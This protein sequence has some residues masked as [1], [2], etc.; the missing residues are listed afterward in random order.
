MNRKLVFIISIVFSLSAAAQKHAPQNW[1]NLDWETDKFPGVSTNKAYIELLK[2]KTPKPVVVAVID[3]GT[4]INHEDLK[5]II[6]VNQKEIAGN[7]IDDDKNGYVDD[8]N[9]WSF[10]SGKDSDVR[11]DN[12]ELVRMYKSLQPLYAKTDSSGMDDKSK[13]AFREYIGIRNKFLEKKEENSRMFE[14]LGGMMQALNTIRQVTGSDNPS[15]KRIKAFE[16]STTMEGLAKKNLLKFN[17]YGMDIPALSRQLQA[18]MDYYGKAVKY[19]YNPDFDTRTIV[20]DNYENLSECCYG[21]NRVSG[22]KGEHGT[23]VAGII[24]AVR[25]NGVGMNGV[26]NSVRIMVL[27]AVPDGDER[28]KDVANAIRYAANNG[29]SIINMSFGKD[30]SPDKKT[31]DEAVKYAMSKDVLIVHAAGNDSKNTGIE[32]NFPNPEYADGSGFAP[33]WIE[34]GASSWRTKKYLTA[35]FSNY[36]KERVDLFAPGVDIYSTLPG[37]SYGS[38]NGTSMAGPVTAGVAAIIRSYYPQFTAAEV[39]EILLQSVTTVKKKVLIPGENHKKTKLL[40]LCRSG[41]IVN[42][43]QAVKLAEERSKTTVRR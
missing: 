14:L 17:K 26:A 5:D 34:V 2:G 23:H 28:D 20:G 16:P 22:P 3:G 11:E 13:K 12:Y 40:E 15:L 24:G 43:F 33:N 8:V 30:Y 32:N 27:R 25:D 39:K 19:S 6:W 29:A 31:V 42:A 35:D 10:I 36:G 9:G 37:Q 4:D 41:G 21:S 18:E 38:Y 1:F 7:G